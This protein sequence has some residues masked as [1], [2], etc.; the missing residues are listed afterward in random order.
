MKVQEQ[1]TLQQQGIVDPLEMEFSAVVRPIMESCTKDSIAVRGI[2]LCYGREPVKPFDTGSSLWS[3]GT[4][5]HG[6]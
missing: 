5:L 1:V 4:R 6:F 2:I 3:L